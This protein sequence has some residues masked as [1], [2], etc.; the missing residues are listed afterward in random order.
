ML[1]NEVNHERAKVEV[2]QAAAAAA[3]VAP[4]K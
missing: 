1:Q 4:E 3:G 2:L